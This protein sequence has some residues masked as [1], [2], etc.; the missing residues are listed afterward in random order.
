MKFSLILKQFSCFIFLI[1][2]TLLLYSQNLNVEPQ[3]EPII[4]SVVK[5]GAI[6]GRSCNDTPIVLYHNGSIY[7]TFNSSLENNVFINV[8]NVSTGQSI[9]ENIEL[10][11]H[12]FNLNISSIVTY[13]VFRIDI[14]CSDVESYVG[15]FSL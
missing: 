3:D 7:V 11:V 6:Q 2:S 4:V 14:I 8:C 9:N 13:G 5:G 1:V 15:Y 12:T 10:S